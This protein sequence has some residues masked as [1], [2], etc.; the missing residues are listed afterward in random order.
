MKHEIFFHFKVCTNWKINRLRTEHFYF[1]L[2]FFLYC[3]LLANLT[4]VEPTRTRLYRSSM[5]WRSTQI[6]KINIKKKAGLCSPQYWMV[7]WIASGKKTAGHE[8]LAS[9]RVDKLFTYNRYI[10]QVDGICLLCSRSLSTFIAHHNNT[11]EVILS[12]TMAI[13]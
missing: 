1:L 10:R 3:V 5:D 7:K 2:F 8:H 12:V 6:D 4:L 11:R 13:A 9:E